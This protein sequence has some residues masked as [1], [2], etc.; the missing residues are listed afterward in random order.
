MAWDWRP[1]PG[2]ARSMK[3]DELGFRAAGREILNFRLRA[4]RS[5]T[6]VFIEERVEVPASVPSVPFPQQQATDGSPSPRDKDSPLPNG[7][8]TPFPSI[9]PTQGNVAAVLQRLSDVERDLFSRISCTYVFFPLYSNPL[10]TKL[11][12]AFC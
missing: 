2:M 6:E 5:R 9:K 7:P 11:F 3:Y 10:R 8:R 1:L 12:L 4:I